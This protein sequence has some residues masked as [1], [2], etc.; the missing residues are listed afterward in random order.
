[1]SASPPLLSLPNELLDRIYSYLDWDRTSLL[2]PYSPDILNVSLVNKHLRASILPRLFRSMALCLRWADGMLLEPELYRLRRDRPD[3]ARHIRCVFITTK[4]GYQP[5]QK[6]KEVSPAF[7][8]PRE[9]EDWLSLGGDDAK[10]SK[11]FIELTKAHRDRVDAEVHI[12]EE[13]LD[14]HQPSM[15]DFELFNGPAASSSQRPITAAGC[16]PDTTESRMRNVL[17]RSRTL[18]ATQAPALAKRMPFNRAT[19]NESDRNVEEVW[20]TTLLGSNPGPSNDF[21][22]YRDVYALANPSQRS[23]QRLKLKV[24]ALA[25]LMLCLPPTLKDLIFEAGVH[26]LE[27]KSWYHF[28]LM[29]M[30]ST[31]TIFGP[32]LESVTMATGTGSRRVRLQS[33]HNFEADVVEISSVAVGALTAL[34]RLVIGSTSDRPENFNVH[35]LHMTSDHFKPWGHPTIVANLTHLEFSHMSFIDTDLT[36]V[37]KFAATFTQLK[38]LRL[39]HIGYATRGAPSRIFP[40]PGQQHVLA[41]PIFLQFCIDLRRSLPTAA[42]IQMDDIHVSIRSQHS[43]LWDSALR[44]I[45][46]EAVPF[47]AKID[48][49]R[50]E[51]LLEDFESFLCLWEAEDSE[52]GRLAEVARESGDLVD[53]AMCNRSR[54][55]EN[56]RRDNGEWTTM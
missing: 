47:G 23:D 49:Q 20:S 17:D 38:S 39:K 24:D 53:T 15:T 55:F 5:G 42:E 43:K 3:L 11:H 32:R 9:R 27:D 12:L 1:M 40:Q 30:N 41:E 28:A 34:R 26:G 52:R 44:W 50:E 33:D 21:T 13:K 8:A 22:Y 10:T 25:A 19:S 18:V 36:K 4:L 56:V 45:M 29:L 48:L 37:V 7:E 16:Q 2:V 35:Q 51:R 31:L 14:T 54:Q 46:D 6:R